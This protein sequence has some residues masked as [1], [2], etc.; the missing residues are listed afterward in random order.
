MNRILVRCATV[1][2]ISAIV[3]IEAGE[4]GPWGDPVS[5][6]AWTK[7][8]LARGFFIQ[9]AF[10]DGKP[11][12]HAEWITS[13]EP[14]ARTFYLG[15]L[16]V[17]KDLQKSGV[18]RAMLAN[19]EAEARRRGCASLSTI[20]DL[21]TGSEVFY[22]KCGFE[23]VRTFLQLDADARDADVP[24]VEIPTIP[25]DVVCGKRFVA[26][27]LQAASRHMYEVACQN[28]D[29]SDRIVRCARIPGGFLALMWFPG[30]DRAQALAW[31]DF[32]A[33]DALLGGLTFAHEIGVPHI[34]LVFDAREADAVRALGIGAFADLDSFEVLKRLG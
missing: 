34:S 20:P 6:E 5:C 21:D 14:D 30:Q 31:G 7:R 27:F 16:Q 19:G 26:G 2:D 4:A 23:R 10:L 17:K 18:G 11:A 15:C 22:Q 3:E 29:S 28:P 25:E 33:G 12:G 9:I 13:D 24:F 1:S 32:S 8:R